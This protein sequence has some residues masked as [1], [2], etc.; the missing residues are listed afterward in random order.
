[1]KK[2]FDPEEICYG[3]K[4][5]FH[6]NA[7]RSFFGVLEREIRGEIRSLEKYEYKI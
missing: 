2:K 4:E 7:E 1:M 5:E 3:V 6:S